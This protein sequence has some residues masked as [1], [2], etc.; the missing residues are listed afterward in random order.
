MHKHLLRLGLALLIGWLLWDALH[1]RLAPH[2]PEFAPFEPTSPNESPVAI[3]AKLIEAA[4]ESSP[5]VVQVDAAELA[6]VAA[7]VGID[8][9]PDQATQSDV[10]GYCV[11]CKTRRPIAGMR[12]E[13]AKDGRRMARG[14]CPVC[15]AKMVRF[16]AK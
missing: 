10:Q 4:L 8:L 5:A 6:F 16:L 7:A 14:I 13:L 9:H 3:P 12:I 2:A 15:G 11:R 1:R